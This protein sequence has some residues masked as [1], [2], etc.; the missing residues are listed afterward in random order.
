M[1]RY[2]ADRNTA[3]YV[4]GESVCL[5]DVS[6]MPR[7]GKRAF[8]GKKL[9]ISRGLPMLYRMGLGWNCCRVGM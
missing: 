4:F 9:A 2:F 1:L 8:D 7:F 5:Y 6:P 3:Q